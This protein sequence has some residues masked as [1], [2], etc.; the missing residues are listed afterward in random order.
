MERAAHIFSIEEMTP[1]VGQGAIGVEARADDAETLDFVAAL[2]HAE[3]H[4]AVTAERAFLD[5]LGAG[6]RMPVGAYATLSGA[7]IRIRGM[8][9]GDEG[10][11]RGERL[12]PAKNAVALGRQL[13]DDLQ[14]SPAAASPGSQ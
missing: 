9:G 13:A 8:V 2:D 5:R 14:A 4:A 6:C 10:I 11:R 7:E 3:T 1:A 12:G